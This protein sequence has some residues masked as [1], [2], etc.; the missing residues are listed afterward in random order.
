MTITYYGHSCFRIE[1]GSGSVVFDPYADG[2]VPGLKLK[3]GI[4]AD[5]V[6][7]SHSHSDHNAEDLITPTGSASSD[8]RVETLYTWHDDAKGAKRGGNRI[9]VVQMD[10]IRAAHLGDIGCEL[11]AGQIHA[12]GKIDVL[13]IPVGGFYTIDA[14]A[15]KKLADEINA[16]VTIPMHYRAE[17]FGL[18][19]IS[20]VGEYTALCDNVEY[21][22]SDT[23]EIERR[24]PGHRT[25]VLKVCG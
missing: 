22:D 24:A 23:L 18:T 7:C 3:R 2:S 10:G 21:P 25:V 9:S 14:A 11:S 8:I 19:N 5:I 13:M 16:S 20:E 6:I 17:N 4:I 1:S 15:A 12:L